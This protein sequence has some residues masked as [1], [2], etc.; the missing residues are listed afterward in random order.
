LDS[1]K[2]EVS[3][4][5]QKSNNVSTVSDKLAT[6]LVKENL[7]LLDNEDFN[8][9]ENINLPFSLDL[10]DGKLRYNKRKGSH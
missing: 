6:P 5:K 8:D 3:I 7:K 1:D 4:L 10:S 2:E 9:Q